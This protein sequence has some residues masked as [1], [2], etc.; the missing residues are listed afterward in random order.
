[1]EY[2]DDTDDWQQMRPENRSCVP[3][4]N[5]LSVIVKAAVCE[6]NGSPAASTREIVGPTHA[7]DN[8][9]V[10]GTEAAGLWYA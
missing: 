6:G 9:G 8:S 10:S 2:A 3:T 5:A 1:M 4:Q 7:T